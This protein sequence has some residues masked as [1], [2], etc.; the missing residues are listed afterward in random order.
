[1]GADIKDAC[2]EQ[3]E[4]KRRQKKEGRKAGRE[5][6]QLT[7]SHPTEKLGIDFDN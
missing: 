5:R 4:E 7:L 6:D 2:G 3:Q 1:M